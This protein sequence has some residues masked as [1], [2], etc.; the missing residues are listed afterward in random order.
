MSW[1]EEARRRR[2]A[3]EKITPISIALGISRY[4][5]LCATDPE[6]SAK[7]AEQVRHTRR[8][9]RYRARPEPV[10]PEIVA[11]ERTIVKEMCD[12]TRISLPRVAWLE[13]PLPE[14]RS[15]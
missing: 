1:E 10:R 7:R 14:V 3:G 11:T 8:P 4:R 15:C 9:E 6:F 5:I 12:G 13:R 2:A